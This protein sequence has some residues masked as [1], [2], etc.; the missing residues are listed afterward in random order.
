MTANAEE[1]AELERWIGEIRR[2]L[3]A[4]RLH[5]EDRFEVLAELG[6][7]LTRRYALD[8]N[9]ADRDEAIDA[10]RLA[11]DAPHPPEAEPGWIHVELAGLL[12]DRGER[13]KDVG[14]VE[15]AIAYGCRGLAALAPADGS[16]LGSGLDDDSELDGDVA[17]AFCDLGIARH[18][19]LGTYHVCRKQSA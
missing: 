17:A 14:D 15:A 12:L 11:D 7:M 2:L 10:L 18:H 19:L 5:V 4:E 9:E 1:R 6:A 16:D 13:G 8:G 3:P